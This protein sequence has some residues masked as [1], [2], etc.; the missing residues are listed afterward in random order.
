[1]DCFF[2]FW[3]DIPRKCE[4]LQ[5][6]VLENELSENPLQPTSCFEARCAGSCSRVAVVAPGARS[7]ATAP[8]KR[9][10]DDD[11]NNKKKK[12]SRNNN[13]KSRSVSAFVAF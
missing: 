4:R 10:D 6:S 7:I 1:M 11:D 3:K 13:K 9:D 2:F 8:L 5:S 12:N